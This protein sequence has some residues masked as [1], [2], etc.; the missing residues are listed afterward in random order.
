MRPRCI[1]GWVVLI[2]AVL[3][4]AAPSAQEQD[5]A[6]MLRDIA[7][8]RRD[9]VSREE[10]VEKAIQ[11]GVGF[12]VTATAQNQ[13]R[14]LGFSPD[15]ISTIKDA[16]NP[17]T[18]T[19]R[20][21]KA[22]KS[23]PLVPG[24]GLRTTD[25]QRDRELEQIEQ[26]IK[27]SGADVLPVELQ[28]FTLWAAKDVQPVFL[29]TIKRLEKFLET[30]FKE[31]IRSGLDKRSAHIILLKNRYE[32][33]NW[34]HAM[35]EVLGDPP[36]D[37]DNPGRAAELKASLAKG[38]GYVPR[39]FA[40]FCMEGQ[41]PDWI[42]RIVAA[43]MGYMVFTQL[44]ESQQNECMATGFA[45]GL[46]SVLAG[47]PRVMLFSN[48][49]HNENRDLGVEPRAWIQLVQQRLATR[50]ISPVGQLLRMDTST[51][52]LPQYAE[53]WSLVGM[54]AKQPGKFGELILGLRENKV[55]LDVI[56]RVYGWDEKQLT[57]E[58]HKFVLGQR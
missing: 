38:F 10:I 46:E 52:L 40:V 9:R 15:Q 35:F 3:L 20:A 13:L 30:R 4:S 34:I 45:N 29:P 55:A 56:E 36:S 2:V 42:H 22:D 37:P 31:P 5:H 51:M 17:H 47:T 25:A 14:R 33:E 23:E 12:E 24:Q 27:K 1:A 6:L 58:W 53:S 18:K 49:Y 48:S 19:G 21:D 8:M 41:Q 28:H 7:Q 11:H 54:L 44:A 32:Y 50:R 39:R 57:Q 16:Y 43:G 26:I